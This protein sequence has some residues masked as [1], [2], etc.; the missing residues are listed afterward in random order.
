MDF[1]KFRT[2]FNAA[3]PRPRTQFQTDVLNGLYDNHPDFLEFKELAAIRSMNDNM[4]K[5]DVKLDSVK[6]IIRG[7]YLHNFM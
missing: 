4:I 3:A 6:E 2:I 1:R 7:M 5:E